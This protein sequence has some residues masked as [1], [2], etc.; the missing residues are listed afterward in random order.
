MRKDLT[1][2]GGVRQEYQSQIGGFHLGPRGGFAWSPFKSGKTTTARRRAASS[3]TGSTPR[4]TSRPC[5]STARISRLKRSCSRDTPIATAGGARDRAALGP[6]AASPT[7]TQPM[8][9]EAIA[10]V[11]QT[12]PKRHPV[13]HDV[14]PPPRPPRAARRQRQRAARERFAAGSVGRSRHRDRSRLRA[15]SSTRLSVNLNYMQPQRRMFIA[16]NYTL[17]AVP[18]T[19][20]TASSVCPPTATTWRPSA[21]RPL[22]DARHRFMSLVNLPLVARFRLATSLRV[23]SALPYNIT[24]G[25]DDNGDTVSNDRPSRCRAQQRPRTGAS[26]YR[27]ASELDHRVW[28]QARRRRPGPAGAHRPRRQRGSARQ[29]RGGG[30]RTS[31]TASSSTCSRTTC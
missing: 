25:H 5:S 23:Q 7:L 13:E 4:A 31:D 3:S 20:P 9:S 28:R 15:R 26:R 8:L 10:G 16:A 22:G 30:D 1:I 21:V 2:T 29:H 14:H 19:R 17:S 6:R 12:L 11:E 24:T 27:R 18:P